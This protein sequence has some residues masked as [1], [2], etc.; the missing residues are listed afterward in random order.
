MEIVGLHVTTLSP[1]WKNFSRHER[2]TRSPYF[3]GR[4]ACTLIQPFGSSKQPARKTFVHARKTF[5]HLWYSLL[6]Y[7]EFHLTN[8][9]DSGPLKK[10]I[11]GSQV[12]CN[13][14]SSHPVVICI[15]VPS[16]ESGLPPCGCQ[17]SPLIICLMLFPLVNS[18]RESSSQFD[19]SFRSFP[20]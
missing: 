16:T 5:I 2:V 9:K 6:I 8:C 7:R 13:L 11:P 15:P 10:Y 4:S 19:P 17:Q 1:I 12:N 3:A 18:Q 20:T 14:S